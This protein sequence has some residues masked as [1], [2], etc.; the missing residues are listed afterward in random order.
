VCLFGGEEPYVIGIAAKGGDVGIERGQLDRPRLERLAGM[1]LAGERQSA[2]HRHERET[3]NHG[4]FFR[5]GMGLADLFVPVVT[6]VRMKAGS[7]TPYAAMQHCGAAQ[8]SQN[9]QKR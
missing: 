8:N 1:S 4:I 3:G 5:L 9:L 7:V 6:K 2:K